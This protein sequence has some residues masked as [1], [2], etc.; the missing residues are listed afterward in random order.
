LTEEQAKQI[1]AQAEE[2]VSL[3][4]KVEITTASVTALDGR[5]TQM[6][7][8][9]EKFKNQATQKGA[10]PSAPAPSAPAHS[11]GPILRAEPVT[12]KEKEF[13]PEGGEIY[14]IK[15]GDNLTNIARQHGTTVSEI[16]KLNKIEDERKL[17]IGQKLILPKSSTPTPP[18]QE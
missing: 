15:R 1:E 11:D 6:T 7:E 4:E 18:A 8:A 9:L 10:L 16:L 5:M 3:K 13:T 12:P 17:Q 2:I 14:T